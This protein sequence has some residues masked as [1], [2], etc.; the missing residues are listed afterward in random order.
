MINTLVV[1]TKKII[2]GTPTYEK[3]NPCSK[4]CLGIIGCKTKY[5]IQ[6]LS[7]YAFM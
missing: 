4:L 2:F 1:V 5:F 7:T 3:T 6:N